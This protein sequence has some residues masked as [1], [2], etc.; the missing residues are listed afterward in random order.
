M[1]LRLHD[2]DL[3]K[4]LDFKN[5]ATW[6][7]TWFGCGLMRP[8]PG[9]WGTL[10]A[11]PFGLIF[12]ALF[13]KVGLGLAVIILLP[14]AFWSVHKFQQ[15][16]DTHDSSMIVI[17]EVAGMWIALLASGLSPLSIVLAFLLFR[18]FDILKPFPVGW[19]DKNLSGAAGVIV[20]DLAAGVYAALCL[21]AINA[22][23]FPG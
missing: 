11:L 21:F 4:K 22:Y 2:P 15:M 16:T 9:T 8:A 20:D 12:L 17:D 19:L 23:A 5:P 10:G 1:K 7:A 3:I 18:F 6:I 13:G 14:I